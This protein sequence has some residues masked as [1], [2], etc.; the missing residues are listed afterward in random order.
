MERRIGSGSMIV[1]V[2]R[3]GGRLVLAV[4]ALQ[5]GAEALWKLCEVGD[6]DGVVR[7]EDRRQLRQLALVADEQPQDNDA[8]P[9]HRR[10]GLRDRLRR[11]IGRLAVVNVDNQ[12]GA[13][14]AF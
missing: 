7:P 3:E 1:W 4:V 13:L 12:P 5:N 14:A 2:E 11:L 6:A 8:V 9:A 10:H